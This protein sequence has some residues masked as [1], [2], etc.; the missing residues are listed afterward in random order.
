LP[1]EIVI[2]GTRLYGPHTQAP[3]LDEDPLITEIAKVIDRYFDK[4]TARILPTSTGFSIDV[5]Q[6]SRRAS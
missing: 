2:G 6:A 1:L 4:G 3:N 5:A